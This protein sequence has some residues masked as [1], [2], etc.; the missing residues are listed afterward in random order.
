MNLEYRY[1]YLS[2]FNVYSMYHI[3]MIPKNVERE[4]KIQK[5]TKTS[6]KNGMENRKPNSAFKKKKWKQ[7]IFFAKKLG[8]R[9]KNR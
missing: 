1:V 4:S 9:E 8:K 2:I 6:C 7:T 3:K 5:T